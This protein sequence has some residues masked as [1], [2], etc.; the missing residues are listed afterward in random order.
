LKWGV[1][2]CPALIFPEENNMSDIRRKQELIEEMEEISGHIEETEDER[3]RGMYTELMNEKAIE[4]EDLE[5][6]ISWLVG[7]YA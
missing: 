5:R 1:G 6:E 4:L 2:M 3:E 7:R